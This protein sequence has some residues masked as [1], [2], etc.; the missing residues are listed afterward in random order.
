MIK[1]RKK[2]SAVILGSMIFILVLSAC[3]SDSGG[4]DLEVNWWGD[5]SKHDRRSEYVQDFEE[6]KDVPTSVTYSGWSG[7]WDKL[8][9]T[10]SGGNTPDVLLMSSRYLRQYAGSGA[11]MELDDKDI[12]LDSFEEEGLDTGRLDG[13]LYG[14][15]TGVNAQVMAYN[16][17]L[18]EDTGVSFDPEKRLTWDEFADLQLEISEQL[19]DGKYGGT[20]NIGTLEFLQYFV[21]DNGETLYDDEDGKSSLGFSEETL[22]DWFNYWFNLQQD[23]GTS[24]AG[25]TASSSAGEYEQQP[26]SK[27]D[28]V[29][30]SRYTNV[31]TT[32]DNITDDN[33][34]MM[35]AP[36]TNKDN[37]P[38][39]LHASAYWVVSKDTEH[40]EESIELLKHLLTDTK[41]RDTMGTDEGV[42]IYKPTKEYLKNNG[43]END[44]AQVSMIQE[45][46]EKVEEPP[47]VEIIASGNIEDLLDEMGENVLFEDLTPDEGAKKFFE[48]AEG[49]IDRN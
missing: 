38:D 35:L 16:E 15:P 45:I 42:P 12:D 10:V 34:K 30:S 1:S 13:K 48:E 49:I 7:Y 28:A 44:Q 29:F 11:L 27:G 3:S 32:I 4:E 47:I 39:Y 23:G 41:V 9:T 2:L 26:I 24:T 31:V 6:E 8:A 36:Q 20:N 21:R 17:D 22:A 46:Q 40:P 25:E 19:P 43:N 37:N 5:Q 33:I 14:I 18:L